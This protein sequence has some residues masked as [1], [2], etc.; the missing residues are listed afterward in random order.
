M[1]VG[2]LTAGGDTP[3]LNATIYGAVERASQ[4]EIEMV[5]IIK[6]FEG[7]LREDV[8]HVRLNP[9][10]QTIPELDPMRGGTILG[11]SR[12]YID[13]EKTEM[14][15]AVSVRLEKLGL[16]GLICIGGDGT[17]NGMQPL[18]EFFPCVLAPKTIDNDLGLNYLDEPND[19]LREDEADDSSYLRQASRKTFELPEIINYATPG[20]ATS[21]YVVTQGLQRIRTTAESHRRIGIVEVMGRQSGYIS[22]GSAYGQPDIIL[23]P[24]VPLNL[25]RL[26][27]RIRELYDLQKHVVIAVGEGLL[28]EDGEELGCSLG[29][30]DPAGNPIYGETAE[31]LRQ[32]LI[33]EMGDDFFRSRMRHNSAAQ[34]IFTRRV[35][36]TQRGGH[37]I[38]FDRFYAAQLGGKATEMIKDEQNNYIA[39]LQWS[40]ERDFFTSSFSAN[41]LRDRWGTI[42]PRMVHH[43]F[44][45]EERFQPSLQGMEFLTKIFTNAIGAEDFEYQRTQT[46]ARSNL[47]QRYQSVNVDI[48]KRIEELR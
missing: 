18:S 35:G 13:P 43:S 48:Q 30:F 45:D 26:K 11:A 1:R 6:G 10:F 46:F 7:L 12:T 29:K 14:L 21:V 9:L 41:K 33:Q 4:L 25:E 39:T 3:A 17:I 20:Y 23:I 44:Y 5:G 32:I 42:H 31:A 38:R 47:L 19:W 37:P 16:D 24:E 28:N 27:N 34:A 36:H 8:P 22:L 15:K 2:I 40:E